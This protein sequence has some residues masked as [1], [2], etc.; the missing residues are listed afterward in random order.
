MGRQ[1]LNIDLKSI[2]IGNTR[3][4]LNL[5]H[6]ISVMR[7]DALYLPISIATT[8]TGWVMSQEL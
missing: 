3:A 4:N 5:K 2:K 6:T 1:Y 7:E 8:A